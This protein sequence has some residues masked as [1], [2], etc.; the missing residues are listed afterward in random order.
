MKVIETSHAE[1]ETLEADLIQ[2]HETICKLKKK[3]QPLQDKL[4]DYESMVTDLRNQLVDQTAI[5]AAN[6]EKL[7]QEVSQRRKAEQMLRSI[8]SRFEPLTQTRQSTNL[9]SESYLLK[10]INY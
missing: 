10:R 5:L 2:S 1:S 4:K 3:V 6:H 8:K 7:L 9:H